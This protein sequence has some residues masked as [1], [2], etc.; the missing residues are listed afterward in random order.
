MLCLIVM[1]MSRVDDEKGYC[2]LSLLWTLLFVLLTKKT[3]M[4][5]WKT[6]C[7]VEIEWHLKTISV[8][9]DKKN[10]I[11]KQPFSSASSYFA[12]ANL[13]GKQICLVG[14][15]SLWKWRK[16]IWR[17]VTIIRKKTKTVRFWVITISY[18]LD[19]STCR[20]WSLH[21]GI[22]SFA[23]LFYCHTGAHHWTQ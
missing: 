2:C 21:C 20:Y 18:V 22:V 6:L 14:K 15:H 4:W 12:L 23:V 5:D 17:Q 13:Q 16:G 1:H 19:S 3:K 9:I 10:T 11:I 7:Q 8:K